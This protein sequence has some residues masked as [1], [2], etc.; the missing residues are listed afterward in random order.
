VESK[1]TYFAKVLRRDTSFYMLGWTPLAYDA[2]NP[3]FSLMSTPG[4]GGQGQFN[5]GSYSNPKVDALTRAIASETD[6]K[7][8]HV[9]IAEAMKIHQD[10]VGHLP[11]HQQAL[12]W[13]VKR[14]IDL[15]QMA[16]GF[17]Y[18]RWVVVK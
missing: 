10:E 5:L 7:K 3:L 17:N 11:L 18:L 14:N 15:V 16:D 6:L 1:A 12:A 4:E 8:R 13:G 2:H 9:M